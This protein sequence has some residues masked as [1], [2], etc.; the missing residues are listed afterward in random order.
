[1]RGLNNFNTSVLADPEMEGRCLSG[2]G[3]KGPGGGCGSGK[4]WKAI[5]PD[6]QASSGAPDLNS[7]YFTHPDKD[8]KTGACVTCGTGGSTCGSGGGSGGS[9]GGE[10]GAAGGVIA[11]ITFWVMVVILPL[12]LLGTFVSAYQGTIEPGDWRRAGQATAFF[13]FIAVC[14]FGV[15]WWDERKRLQ[16]CDN[17]ARESAETIARLE[18]EKKCTD[19]PDDTRRDRLGKPNRKNAYSAWLGAIRLHGPTEETFILFSF[20]SHRDAFC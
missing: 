16:H 7:P 10:A 18:A 3:R 4:L 8:P 17:V 13:A 6:G 11:V 9:S 1:M 5:D 15:P 20:L 19:Q 12:G 14:L 2:Q